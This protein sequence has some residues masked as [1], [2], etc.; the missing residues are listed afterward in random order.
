MPIE[1]NSADRRQ[2]IGE[3]GV[4]IMREQ[5]IAGLT[6]RAV[7]EALGGSTSLVTNYVRNRTQLL[8]LTLETLAHQWDTQLT[9]LTG[10]PDQQL[11]DAAALAVDWHADSGP[12]VAVLLI[13]ILAEKTIDPQRLTTIHRELDLLH[14]RFDE[15]VRAADVAE[16]DAA[17]DLLYLVSRGT[18]LTLVEN[19]GDW[20]ADRLTR[21]ADHL[22]RLLGTSSHG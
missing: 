10:P 5:G 14:H 11:R 8:D 1:V 13:Q 22:T 18:M 7:A 12:A 21:A 20:P 19:L 2:Q 4:R 3:A 15:V 9:Q 6:M 17:A 16:P